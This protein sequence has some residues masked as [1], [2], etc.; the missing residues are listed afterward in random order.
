[1]FTKIL[2]NY[3]FFLITREPFIPSQKGL[4]DLAALN[5][6]TNRHILHSPDINKAVFQFVDET[7]PGDD[8]I[9]F[10]THFYP[11]FKDLY[12]DKYPT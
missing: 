6:P 5:I 1:M 11:N 4:E 7:F 12:D 2:F 8:R 3:G 9:K 10:A